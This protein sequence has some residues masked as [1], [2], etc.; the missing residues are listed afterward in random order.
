MFT[1]TLLLYFYIV[2]TKKEMD[3]K[4][5]SFTHVWSII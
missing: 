3:F 5:Y 2:N 1:L 4:D